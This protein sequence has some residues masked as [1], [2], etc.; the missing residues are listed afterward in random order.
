[1]VIYL[2]DLEAVLYP[3]LGEEIFQMENTELSVH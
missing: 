3:V 2:C 1:M